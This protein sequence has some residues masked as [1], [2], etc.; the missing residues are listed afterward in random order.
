MQIMDKKHM[1]STIKTRTASWLTLLSRFWIFNRLIKYVLYGLL[2]GRVKR[3][4]QDIYQIVDQETKNERE[5]QFRV[6]YLRTEFWLATHKSS[7]AAAHTKGL[8]EEFARRKNDIMMISSFPIDYIQNPAIKRQEIA[9]DLFS[10]S[11]GELRELEYNRQF[12]THADPYLK[13]YRPSIIYHRYGLNSYAAAFLSKTMGIPMILEYNGSEIWMSENW[14][15]RLRFRGIAEKIEEANFSAARLI[16][17]NAQPL[18]NELISRG[19]PAEKIIIIPNG[20]DP[21]RFSPA[22]SGK[23]IREYHGLADDQIIVGFL[24]TFGPWHGAE[25]LARSIKIIAES[26][27]CIHFLYVGTGKTMAQVKK[28]IENDGTTGHV[29]FAGVVRQMEAP[30]YL[31]ACDILVSPQIPNPD[32][33]PF[34][35]SP[36][37]LFEYMAMGKPIVASDL[38]QLGEILVDGKTAVLTKPGDHID[39]A[40]KILML[41]GKEDLMY[42]LGENARQLVIEKYTWEKHVEKILDHLSSL[43]NIEG[44]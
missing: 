3:D 36:T 34:F 14:G 20:V 37:K 41:S 38:D 18:K 15:N 17:G 39:L 30:A 33:T 25:V 4:L 31:G 43:G 21:D 28:I 1:T 11:F 10:F 23:Y 5:S 8:V 35:G 2:I 12:V 13:E 40:K 44:I 16:I 6:A 7:G 22:I 32:G 26:N 9:P 24:G 29:T 42:Q 27:P 19:V